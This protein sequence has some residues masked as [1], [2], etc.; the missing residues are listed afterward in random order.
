MYFF[1]K[2]FSLTVIILLC[3]TFFSTILAQQI[4]ADLGELYIPDPPSFV[5]NYEYDSASDLYYYNVKVGDYNIN[6]PIILSP[7]EYRKLKLKEDLKEYYKSKIDAAEGKK[8]GTDE[9]QK[10][11]IPEIYVNS[12]VFES[13]FGGN[14]IQVVPQG[15]LEADFGIL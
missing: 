14:T 7:E 9:D 11:L 15:S 10:N 3:T 13:I 6:Y 4:E 8:D 1:L 12:Q 2:N 5:D